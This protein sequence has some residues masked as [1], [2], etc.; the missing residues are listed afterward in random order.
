[1]ALRST[2]VTARVVARSA[3]A[4]SRSGALCGR[5]FSTAAD[6]EEEGLGGYSLKLSDEQTALKELRASLRSRR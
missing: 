6:A 1:M 4:G 5:R 3:F 2:R